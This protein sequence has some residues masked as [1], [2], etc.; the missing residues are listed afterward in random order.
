[1][2]IPLNGLIT[3][4]AILTALPATAQLPTLP[5]DPWTESFLV[6]SERKF[7][8]VYSQLGKGELD[9]IDR[10]NDK[11]SANNSIEIGFE[12]LE[13]TS[14]DKMVSKKIQPYSLASSSPAV[15]NPK[16]PVTITG[17]VTGDA[18][19]EI[20]ITPGKS[21]IS[22]TG[23]I[24]DK[25]TLTKPLTFVIS[26]KV[27]PYHNQ[28]AS[29]KDDLEKFEK[30]IKREE[31][32]IE[33]LSGE[34]EEIDLT[35]KLNLAKKFPEGIKSLEFD[36]KAY[37]ETAFTFASSGKSKII[38]EDDEENYVWKTF[39]LQWIPDPTQDPSTQALTITGK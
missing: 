1:M 37:G 15:K 9:P 3:I 4:L 22:L 25:G 14:S 10:H 8:F 28:S 11:I 35:E 30:T 26:A 34:E 19:F 21:S 39:T 7:Q 17:L 13:A 5:R 33:L 27:T 23:R 20:T 29:D 12:V 6:I 32:E 31:L 36:T 2:K 38:F 18:A 16:E 24:T